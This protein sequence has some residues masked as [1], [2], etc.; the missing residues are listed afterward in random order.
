M[1]LKFLQP[2]RFPSGKHRTLLSSVRV[3]HT[4]TAIASAGVIV[5]SLLL[6]W[7]VDKS[8][9]QVAVLVATATVPHWF[10][11]GSARLAVALSPNLAPG[12]HVT[13]FRNVG[14]YLGLVERP[15][16]L[17]ALVTGNAEFIAAWFVLKGIAGFRVGGPEVRA[18]RLFQL[19]LLNNA[20][21]LAGVAIGWFV[22]TQ[23]GLS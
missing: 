11:E 14:A 13:G 12:D 15:L 7:Y 8:W 9:L 6:S 21:S 2:R 10:V 20:V 4:I 23:L 17:A 22:W 1:V 19:F 5:G 18:R 3:I 16:F